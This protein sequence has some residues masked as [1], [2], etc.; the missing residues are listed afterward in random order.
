MTENKEDNISF[1]LSD[2]IFNERPRM[3]DLRHLK[4]PSGEGF[5]VA[6]SIGLSYE[7]VG[8]LLLNDSSG[9]EVKIIWTDMKEHVVETNVEI[10]RRWLK[11]SGKRPVTWRTLI[12]VLMD[13]GSTELAND[14]RKALLSKYSSHK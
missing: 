6:A 13:I 14:I 10:L 5:D 3:T 2:G 9:N 12:Q 4:L 1:D 11:G 7:K 8:V